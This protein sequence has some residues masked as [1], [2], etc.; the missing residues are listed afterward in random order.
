M[1]H[2][3]TRTPPLLDSRVLR[4][5]PLTQWWYAEDAVCVA[6][7][8]VSRTPVVTVGGVLD[9]QAWTPCRRALGAALRA[10]PRCVLVDLEAVASGD[11]RGAALLG[12][13]RRSALWHGA[14]LWLAAVPLTVAQQLDR[15]GLAP[16]FPISRNATRAIEEIRRAQLEPGGR[17]VAVDPRPDTRTA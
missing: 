11:D 1:T 8:S 3:H 17:H 2:S 14:R 12:A 7:R 4:M 10:R 16:A 9:E 6:L 15:L 13:M 5:E